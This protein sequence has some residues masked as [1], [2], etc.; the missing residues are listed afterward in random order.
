MLIYLSSYPRS[1]NT[2]VRQ[3]V[4]HYFGYQSASIYPE[5]QGTPNLDRRP[6]G[7][8]ELFASYESPHHPGQRLAMLVNNCGAILSPE[9]RQRLGAANEIYF[10]KTHELPFAEY[11][12]GEYVLHVVREPGAV[13]WSYLNFLRK[14]EPAHFAQLTLD[15]VIKGKVPFGSWSQHAQQW[16]VAGKQLGSR[17]MLQTYENLSTQPELEFC[18]QVKAF[19]GLTYNKTKRPLPSLDHWHQQAPTLYRKEQLSSWREHYSPNQ[20][21]LVLRRHEPMLKQLGYDPASYATSLSARLR[22]FV[23]FSNKAQ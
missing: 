10:L 8:Y 14:N 1:G 17:F 21:H 4:R 12:P 2:W 15:R 7:S 9:L 16:L 5:P 13:F 6:D 19:T 22:R 3:L 20:L 11:Y 23:P 18:D